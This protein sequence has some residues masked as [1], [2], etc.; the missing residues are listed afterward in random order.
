MAA[1]NEQKAKN[2]LERFA[3]VAKDCK[4]AGEV[5]WLPLDLD[6]PREVQ[7]AAEVFMSKEDRL[8]ILSQLL[9]Q[10]TWTVLITSFHSQQCWDV[11]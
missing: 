5:V 11:S 9:Q 2:A 3:E 8:D 6:D 1:R 7:R 4:D 10:A